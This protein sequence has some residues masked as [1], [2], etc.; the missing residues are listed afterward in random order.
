MVRIKFL[1]AAMAMIAIPF[2]AGCGA[3]PAGTYTLDASFDGGIPKAASCDDMCSPTC[4]CR[5]GEGDCDA[6]RDCAAGLFCPPDGTGIERCQVAQVPGDGAGAS[7]GELK[8]VV[9]SVGSADSAL[10]VFPTGA[11]MLMDSATEARARD[12]VLPFLRRHGITHLDYYAETHPHPDHIGGG[13]VLR[14]SGF[15]TS[16]TEVWDWKTHA[17]GDAFALEG[18]NWFIYNARDT[19]FH[20]TDANDNSLSFRME[21]N[22]FVYSST[23]D[24]GVRS[25]TRFLNNHPKLVPAHVRNTAHHLWGPVSPKFDVATNPYLFII[26]SIRSVKEERSW[27]DFMGAVNTLKT[28]GGR[29]REHALTAEVGHVIVRARDAKDWSYKFCPD[30]NTC[31]VPNLR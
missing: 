19:A 2:A 20:G 3:E 22:G 25:Q 29:L 17:Y 4:L 31:M 7:K 15:V 21:Y 11:T 5:A 14:S 1:C 24:E 12:R 16:T 8:I 26:S 6:D 10:I 27:R 13:A 30:M 28:N 18:T 9:F 23:G